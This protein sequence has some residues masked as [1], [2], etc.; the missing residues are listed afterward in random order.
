MSKMETQD[1]VFQLPI[2]I[3]ENGT[4]VKTL[5][6]ADTYVDKNIVVSVNVPD[7]TYEI[8]TAA[9]V[10]ATVKS[11]DTTYTSSTETAYPVEIQ[12]DATAGAVVVGVETAG[13]AAASDTVTVSAANAE[14]N[15]KTIYIKEGHLKGSGEASATS[16]S[17]KLTKGSA[18]ATGFVIK[19]SAAGGASVDVAGWLPEGAAADASGDT[20]YKVQEASLANT[21][22]ASAEELSAPV[23]VEGGYLYINEGYIKDSK[24]SLATLIPDNAVIPGVV[25][26]QSDLMYNTVSAYD[27]DGNLI[28]GTMGNATL[29]AIDADDASA[30]INSVSVTAGEGGA[31]KVSGTAAISGSTSV[32]V[33]TRGLA[34]T[35]L[36]QSG[37]ISGTATVD[38]SLAKVGLNVDVDNDDITV[39]PVIV[40][41]D[42]SNG[43]F[44][45]ATNTQPTSGRYVAVSAAAIAASTTVSPKVASAGYGTADQF[46]ATGATV[47]AGSEAADVLYIPMVAASHDAVAGTPTVVD[48]TATVAMNSASSAGFVGDLTAGILASAPTS[49]EYITI[50]SNTSVTAGSVSGTVTC[51]STEGYIERSSDTASISESVNVNKTETAK[52]IKVYDGAFI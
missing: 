7:A 11:N 12:A 38:A 49:G 13:F 24:I 37:V 6:T 25:N 5:N 26:G 4:V 17:V 27:K 22:N 45:T 52:Y 10:T 30:T 21:G 39:K 3:T 28:A 14:A 40:K 44:G 29:G 9:D 1:K 16:S 46:D 36:S 2:D 50:S 34:E 47:T 23:L 33:A 43:S 20:Y 41:N 15:K 48:A 42:A 8:K 32:S 18:D 51:T 19:A 31:F 35:S